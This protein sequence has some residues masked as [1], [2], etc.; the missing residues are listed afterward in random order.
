MRA[1]EGA[2]VT[3]EESF[4]AAHLDCHA[5]LPTDAAE[6]AGPRV[7]EEEVKKRS[8]V[9]LPDCLACHKTDAECDDCEELQWKQK[10]HSTENGS[11]DAIRHRRLA[12]SQPSKKGPSNKTMPRAVLVS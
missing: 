10:E 3:T 8:S 12:Y 1:I 7:A 2:N 11:P 4:T 6:D 5:K 9:G